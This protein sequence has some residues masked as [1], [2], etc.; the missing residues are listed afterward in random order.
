M[1]LRLGIFMVHKVDISGNNRAS[2]REILKRSGLREGESSIFFFEN[3]VEDE[4]K[5]NP[6]IKKVSVHK[7]FPKKVTIEVEEEDVYCI[8][9]SDDGS[10][11]YMSRTG[12]ILGSGNF[13][14][15]LDFPVLI[16]DGIGD[17]KLLEE[18]LEILE[19]SKKSTVLK[20]DEISEVQVDSVYGINVLTNDAR[21]I[22]FDK[23]NIA[24]K[25]DNVERIIK[26]SNSLGLRESY[27]NVSS[28][29]FGVVDFKQPVVKSGAKDG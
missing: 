29:S 24:G 20:W 9:L 5:K 1:T 13:S 3:Q 16:G 11:R 4:I 8:V 17:P 25:W 27:I 7:E 6:W 26:Y 10:F 12:G 19:L 14:M 18:A 23:N 28:D 15:G 2:S 21:R 22:E